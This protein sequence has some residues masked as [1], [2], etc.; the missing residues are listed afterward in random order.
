MANPKLIVLCFDALEKNLIDAGDYDNLKL[1]TNGKTDISEFTLPKSVILWSSFLTSE[2]MERY[3][4]YLLYDFDLGPVRIHIPTSV[5]DKFE[6]QIWGGWGGKL[7]GRLAPL[8]KYLNERI[9][10]VRLRPEETFLEYFKSYTAIDMVALT[11]KTRRHKKERQLMSDYFNYNVE[12]GVIDKIRET[13]NTLYYGDGAVPHKNQKNMMKRQ[14]IEISF[15]KFVW[16][17]YRENRAELF[18]ALDRN[19]EL[20]MFFTPLADLIG[21]LYFGSER[22]M[23]E[24][25]TEL[26]ALVSYVVEKTKDKDTTIIGVS[27]HGMERI[28][29]KTFDGSVRYTRYGDHSEVKQGTYFINKTLDE[30]RD[31]YESVKGEGEESFSWEEQYQI[32]KVLENLENGNPWLRDVYH[33]IK[34]YGSRKPTKPKRLRRFR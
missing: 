27:D 5:G 34:I 21:H 15:K 3:L 28:A 13:L 12:E 29:Y 9:W 20:V 19:Y 17:G 8:R 23:E 32:K 31:R 22:E 6:R 25:Y 2:N 30:I 7:L 18:D 14:K 26:N 11:H 4:K 16:N 33:I 10:R 1:V 24:V